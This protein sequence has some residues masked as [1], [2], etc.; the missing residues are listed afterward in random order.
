MGEVF[1]KVCKLLKVEKIHATAYHPES[2][3]ALERTHK[4]L[5]EYL[6]C[7]CN[8]K[9][10]NW[11]EWLPFACF[12]Y[13]TTPHSVT[14]FTPYGI[15][16]GRIANI[17]GTLQRQPEPVYNYDDIIFGIK[18]KMQECHKKAKERLIQFKEKQKEK[19]KSNEHLFKENYLVLLRMEARQK[20]GPLW[21]GPFEIKEVRGSNAVIQ[22]L[23]KR[24][25]QE[26]HT[27]RLKPYFSSVAGV[28]HAVDKVDGCSY[29]S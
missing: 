19:V 10:N 26:V 20:L 7:F 11:D 5:T 21:K 29:V 24:K 8:P 1:K 17:P 13:T 4:T 22:E 15:L 27:N 3:G 12:A 16:F 23:G 2:N 18:Y 14:K 28:K 25:R 9:L 6:R